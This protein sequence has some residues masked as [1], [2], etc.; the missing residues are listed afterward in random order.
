MVTRGIAKLSG[1]SVSVQ[2]TQERLAAIVLYWNSTRRSA[3]AKPGTLSTES[4]K[5]RPQRK[6]AKLRTMR[7]YYSLYDRLLDRRALARAFEKVR[8]AKGA[9]GIDGQTIDDFEADLLGEL[10]HRC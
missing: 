6:T 10:T 7:T 5:V 8:R 9:P 3:R 1:P 4:T 2:V